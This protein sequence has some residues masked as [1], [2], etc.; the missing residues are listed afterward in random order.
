[1]PTAMNIMPSGMGL[2]SAQAE[3]AEPGDYEVRVFAI[4]NFTQLELL[5]GIQKGTIE[6]TSA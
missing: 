2:P 3:P 5:S 1:M 6:V 4:S